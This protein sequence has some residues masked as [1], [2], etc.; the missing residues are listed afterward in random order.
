MVVG[1]VR[2]ALLD[3]GDL[4][5][6]IGRLGVGQQILGLPVR[7]RGLQELQELSRAARG[8]EEGACLEKASA[9]AARARDRERGERRGRR[10]VFRDSDRTR[11]RALYLTPEEPPRRGRSHRR[12][13]RFPRARARSRDGTR[14]YLG[15]GEVLHVHDHL[16]PLRG[17]AGHLG[18]GVALDDDRGRVHRGG[19]GSPQLGGSA[20]GLGAG[21]GLVRARGGREHG[22][23]GDARSHLQCV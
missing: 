4:V 21:R 17:E 1:D 12:R 16:A 19:P 18:L 10:R 5:E 15:L 2:A 20:G 6:E 13:E 23:L 9:G 11:G 3:R 7:G 8:G 22:A 14:A